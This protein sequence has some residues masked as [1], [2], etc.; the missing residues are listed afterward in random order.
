[1][2]RSRR[3]CYLI[4]LLLI[5]TVHATPLEASDTL[6][7]VTWREPNEGAY[8]ISVPQGWKVSGGVRRRTPVDVRTAVNVVSP[9]GTI[10][11]FIGDYDVPPA[12]EPDQLTR[13]AGMRE[14]QIY[15]GS[16]SHAT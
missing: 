11:L 7:F 6:S 9:D 14:G 1:M 10:R 15:D 4:A 16:C 13:T 2:T 3:A 5:A 8:T 12:R